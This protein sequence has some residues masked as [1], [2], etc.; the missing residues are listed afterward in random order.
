MLNSLA[1]R[2]HLSMTIDVPE[3]LPSLLADGR[4]VKQIL[5]NLITNA[6]KFT[7]ENGQVTTSAF[8]D[9]Q[10]RFCLSIVDTG[11][12]IAEEDIPRVLIPFGQV[13]NVFSRSKEGTGLGLPLSKRLAELHEGELTI[14]S[15]PGQGTA[16]SV[17]FP[18]SRVMDKP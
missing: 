5:I 11:I 4:I 13:E 14:E 18:A 15:Y 1:R 16:V 12:G 10:G 9:E 6:I 17:I 2:G 3:G 7:P 8:I